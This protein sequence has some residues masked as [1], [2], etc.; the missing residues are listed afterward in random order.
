MSALTQWFPG[1]I[2]PARAGV[3][4]RDDSKTDMA[5]GNPGYAYFDG[6]RWRAQSNS[7]RLAAVRVLDSSHQRLPWRG[8]ADKPEGR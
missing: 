2:K 6:K 8:L 3:Y 5:N 1:S 4:E 7:V